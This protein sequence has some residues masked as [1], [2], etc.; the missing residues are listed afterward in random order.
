MFRRILPCVGVLALGVALAG[1]NN[2]PDDHARLD[3]GSR[4]TGQSATPQSGGA[5]SVGTRPSGAITTT[6]IQPVQ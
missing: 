4:V 6:P 3:T 5:A 1:C 2:P